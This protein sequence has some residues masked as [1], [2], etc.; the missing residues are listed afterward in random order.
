M[1]QLLCYIQK[2]GRSE[3]KIKQRQ[4]DGSFPTL[5]DQVERTCLKLKLPETALLSLRDSKRRRECQGQAD[6]P[7]TDVLYYE[8]LIASWQGEGC[9]QYTIDVPQSPPTS[10]I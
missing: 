6:F 5:P 8:R 7:H 1:V 9:L 2:G 4:M 3:V 10:S